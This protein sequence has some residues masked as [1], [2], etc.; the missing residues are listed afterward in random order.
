MLM[1]VLLWVLVLLYLSPIYAVSFTN[2]SLN[3]EYEGGVANAS[4]NVYNYYMNLKSA[5][6]LVVRLNV[7]ILE[8]Q[9]IHPVLVVARQRD[10]VSAFSLP[11]AVTNLILYNNV[12]RTL[13]PVFLEPYDSLFLVIELSS[14]SSTP[15]RYKLRVD[16]L[17]GFDLRLNQPVHLILR[18]AQPRYFR[19]RFPKVSRSVAIK[20]VSPDDACM[21]LAAQSL[22]CPVNDGLGAVGTFGLHQ[23]VTTLGTLSINSL[24]YNDG[25]YVILT[26]MANDI[27]CTG[28][29]NLSPI[30][31]SHHTTFRTDERSKTLTLTV[32]PTPNRLEYLL[33]I[34]ITITFFTSFYAVAILIVCIHQ[35]PSRRTH[36]LVLGNPHVCEDVYFREQQSLVSVP[37]VLCYGSTMNSGICQGCSR[38]RPTTPGDVPDYHPQVSATP[39]DRQVS[40]SDHFCSNPTTSSM[41]GGAVRTTYVNHS[42]TQREATEASSQMD[43]DLGSVYEL[44][45]SR[46]T[47][48]T[49]VADLSRKRYTTLT[50]KYMLYFWYL[51]IISIFYALPT[52]QLIMIYQKAL[53]ESG[54]EDLC[55]YNFECARPFGIFTAFNNIISNAGYVLLGILFLASVA[56]RDL[57]HRRQRKFTP[58][59]AQTHGI[60]Q[61]YGLFY[62]MGLALSMEGIM[63]ACYHMCP[64]FSNF[65]FDTAYMYILAALI[66]LKIYQSRHPD[67][68]ASAHSA[69]MV[70]AVVIL[71]GVT[72]VI[73][74]GETFWIAFT[75]FFLLMSV[76]LTAEVY[77]MGRWTFDLCLS[78]RLYASIRSDGIRCLRPAYPQRMV[79]LLVANVV[80]FALAG[81][82]IVAQPRD[83]SSFLLSIFMINVLVYTLFYFLMK[84]VHH[85]RIQ[86]SPL[87]YLLAGLLSWSVA[88][89]FFVRRITTWES[90]PA[91][92]RAHNQPCLLFDFY[93]AHDIWHFLSATSM[94]FSFM[95]LLNLDDDLTDKPRNQIAVF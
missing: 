28:L 53:V 55:Y 59:L 57:L 18:P 90:T 17:D 41:S 78:S 49:H 86:L 91:Q 79:L 70:M 80:N 85:E 10:G 16:S 20:A 73:Y 38:T 51:I 1:L 7:V 74:G 63:S 76:L 89:V 33:P 4:L 88:M 64:S 75:I 60:P 15:I 2:A 3:E 84:L 93:D 8:P 14:F 77:Y 72:G 44:Q 52:V 95:M 6:E 71:L 50:R 68:N 12:S 56:H 82:G 46:C 37:V 30:P 58:V 83:F 94:F 61:H 31:P 40:L 39:F 35:C 29:E 48:G 13:C 22:Q 34:S 45:S 81:Y 26:L 32:L 43:I 87:L 42:T 24:Q 36:E 62:S 5:K 47:Y 66:M 19:Y 9:D 65:Q 67:I 11:F 54:N 92:S 25:F 23:T 27:F 21:M 69:Y